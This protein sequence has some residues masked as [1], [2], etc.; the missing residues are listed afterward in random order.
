MTTKPQFIALLPLRYHCVTIA[1]LAKQKNQP[2]VKA[3]FDG[4]LLCNTRYLSSVVSSI[5]L[6]FVVWVRSNSGELA[7]TSVDS[8]TREVVGLEVVQ[9]AEVVATGG[10][11]VVLGSMLKKI[12]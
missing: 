9:L 5:E 8:G 1:L 6:A 3:V 12:V 2:A 7:R 4:M 10:M 11:V